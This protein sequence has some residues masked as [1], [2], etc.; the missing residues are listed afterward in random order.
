MMMW[1]A[2]SSKGVSEP[3]FLPSKG[4]VN[5]QFFLNECITKRLLPFIREYHDGDDIVFWPDLAS[6][7]YA[8]IVIESLRKNQVVMVQRTINPPNLPQCRP[9]KNFWAKL[10]QEVYKDGWEASSIYQLNLRIKKILKKIDLTS[11]Q[12]EIL[13]IA[14]KLRTVADHGPMS[15]L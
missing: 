12:T 13:H 11:V 14:T 4:A 2:I 15:I 8:K 5:A 10:E 9:I 1:I 6:S 7:H 3:F